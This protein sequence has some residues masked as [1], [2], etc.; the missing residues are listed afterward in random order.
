MWRSLFLAVG[1]TLIIVGAE[2]LVVDSAMMA[3]D[4]GP[5]PFTPPDW[6][7]WSMMS[8]GAIVILYS[9]TIPKRMNG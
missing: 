8:S 5:K 4:G 1:I 6:A 3:S 9:F 7:P 2:C